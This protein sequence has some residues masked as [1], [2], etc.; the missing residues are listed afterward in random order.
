MYTVNFSKSIS[1]SFNL[2]IMK[3]EALCE[4]MTCSQ[5]ILTEIFSGK[6]HDVSNL[7]SNGLE[8]NMVFYY[9]NIS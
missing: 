4:R 3:L 9:I 2:M 7:F 6:G 1:C 8:N 5:E